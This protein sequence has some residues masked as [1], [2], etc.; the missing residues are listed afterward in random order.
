[1]VEKFIVLLRKHW[2]L[3]AILLLAAF[4][5][6]YR[7]GDYLTFLGDEGR[8]A[9]AVYNILHGDFT[10]LGPRSSAADFYYG[11]IYFYLIAPFLWLFGYDPVGPAVFVALLGVITVY[12]VY[13]VGKELMHPYAGLVA[14]ALYAVS[15]IVVIYSKTSWNPNPLP[16]VALLTL[17][18]CYFAVR[19]HALKKFFLVGFLLGIALQLQY[20]ALSLGLIVAI[21]TLVG[22]YLVQKEIQLRRYL[23]QYSVIF[24]GFLVGFSP[25]LAF[26]V[27]HGFPNIRTIY[28]YIFTHKVDPVHVNGES[29]AMKVGEVI[30]RLFGRLITRFP[31]LQSVNI[32]TNFVLL[33][34]YIATIL[35]A[36]IC[37]VGIVRI[38][39]TL[40][41]SL[42]IVWLAVAAGSFAFSKETIYDYHLGFSFPL[43]FLLLGNALV[44][45]L[46]VKK[47]QPMLRV[48]TIGFCI[49]LVI[50]NLAGSSL[51]YPPNKQKDQVK[52][53]ANFIV[54]KTDGKPFNFALI[55]LGNSDHAYRYYFTL[56]SH[57]PVVIQNT[58]VDPQ[59]KSVTD[60]LFVVCEDPNCK[61]LGNSLW[62]VA[63]FGR[64]EI[65]GQWPVSVLKVFKLVHYTGLQE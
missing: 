40:A 15:P 3:I 1:M 64:A 44:I 8:D 6:F 55:T 41:K 24:V 49:A 2:I 38:K 4:L 47:W 43:P 21:Y 46:T 31:E 30:F 10:L 45:P 5:R 32:H 59:R 23:T 7:I 42:F 51:L 16:F 65:V 39:N 18:L 60:Q 11:P 14:A 34:W 17:Y 50:F 29:P 9:L 25:F 53:I 58:D 48:V 22:T 36:I 63:G 28:A 61:P 56:A 13:R 52:E 19:T 57:D 37:I 27:K 12:L 26:E 35:L 62:E 33:L 54:E 20:M